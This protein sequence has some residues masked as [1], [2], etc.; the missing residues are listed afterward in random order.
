MA[1][2]LTIG[3]TASVIAVVNRRRSIIRFQNTGAV[4]TIFI[5][6][7]LLHLVQLIMKF[8]LDHQ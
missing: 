7:Y 6:V 8:Y 1:S 2:P 4:T 3:T 5:K